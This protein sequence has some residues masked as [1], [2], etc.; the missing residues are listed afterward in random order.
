M[1]IF[2]LASV[3]LPTEKAHGIQIMKTCEAFSLVGVEITLGVPYFIFDTERFQNP[4]RYYGLS[5]TFKIKRTASIRLIK[6]GPAGFFLE[7]LLFFIG[8]VF[9]RDFWKASYIFSRDEMLVTLASFLGKKTIW[10]THTGSY[11]FFA[12]KALA[13]STLIVS[14]SKGLKEFYVSKG[15]LNSKIAV[16]HDAVDLK[17]F[18]IPESKEGARHILGLPLD[19]K[20]VLY[21]G[22]LDGW[23]GA[24]TF[25]ESSRSFPQEVKAVV[26]GGEKNQIK[27]FSQKYPNI[28]FLG[29]KNY[30]ELPVCQKSADILVIPNTSKDK[31]SQSFTSPLKV[32]TYMAA[33]VPIVASDLPSIR[34][35]LNN[36]N[37]I[38]VTPDNPQALFEG[39]NFLLEDLNRADILA[40]Q[41]LKDVARHSWVERAKKIL[42]HL[43]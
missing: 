43:P 36:E 15:V 17:D 40:K 13:R 24:E 10:E 2:Y 1:N 9:C 18:N 6:F 31:V 23:K 34:E 38:L 26:V 29:A 41:A 16:A 37:S 8:V 30:R 42:S 11:N 39:I 27:F 20:I 32:F 22:R 4:F 19:K 3:R 12:R 25:F 14:I 33:G 35:I 7:S 5:P 28:M 21:A